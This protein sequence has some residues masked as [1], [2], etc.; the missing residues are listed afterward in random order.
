MCTSSLKRLWYLHAL[1]LMA[2]GSAGMA[3]DPPFNASLVGQWDDYDGNYSDIWS[4][5][6]YAY[7]PNWPPADQQ[8]GQVH[9]LDISDP[10]H[11]VLDETIFLEFPNEFA[12]PQDVKVG[13]GLLFIGLESTP[14]DG[15]AIYDVRDPADRQLLTYVSVPGFLTVHN[16]FYD[17]GFLYIPEGTSVAIVDLTAFDPDNPPAEIV[18]PTWLLEN[19]G[20]SFIHDVTVADGRLYCAAWDSGLWVYDVANIATEAPTFLGST[21]GDNTHSMWPTPDGRFVVTG[22]ERSGGGIQVYEIVPAFPGISLLLRDSVTF[23]TTEAS[24]VHNQIM[25]GYRVFNSWYDK[26]MQVFDVNPVTG[27]LAP[28]ASYDTN[29]GTIGL[30]NWGIYPLLGEDRILLSDGTHGCLIVTLDDASIPTLSQWGL[31]VLGVLMTGAGATIVCGR[32][33]TARAG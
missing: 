14:N 25:V 1:I 29:V 6:Q 27:Q 13:D 23:P 33:V 30:G 19:V 4:D 22:E 16:L 17:S 5:G 31:I 8:P 9:I 11:P 26:G 28:V 20:T 32:R 21:P 18:A 12:S 2:A 10:A 3:Q 15:V 7:L 24:S